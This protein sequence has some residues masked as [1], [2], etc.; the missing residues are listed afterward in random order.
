MSKSPFTLE[1]TPA[2]V[3]GDTATTSAETLVYFDLR[4]LRRET[5]KYLFLVCS[6]LYALV[7][8]YHVRYASLLSSKIP[9]SNYELECFL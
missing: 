6:L 7:L 3:V 4:N 5:M 8:H 2:L 9:Y 1:G